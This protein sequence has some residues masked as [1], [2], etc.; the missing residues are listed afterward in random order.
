MSSSLPFLG[1]GLSYRWE[2]NRFL[3][4][5]AGGVDWLEITPEHFMPLN[6]DTEARLALLARRV[7]LVGHSLELSIRADGPGAPGRL[8]AAA[9]SSHRGGQRRQPPV[10]SKAVPRPAAA[11]SGGADPH[12]RRRGSGGDTARLPLFVLPGGGLRSARVRGAE[13]PG[14]RGQL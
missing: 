3:A 4:R 14:S 6:G 12:R 8:R 11:R 7:P 1:V 13:V 5:S 9:R 10:R 2:L